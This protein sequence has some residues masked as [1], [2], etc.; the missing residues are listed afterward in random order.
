MRCRQTMKLPSR[1]S[2]A[3]QYIHGI[4]GGRVSGRALDRL[5]KSEA[6]GQERGHPLTPPFSPLYQLRRAPRRAPRRALR[7]DTEVG[8]GKGYKGSAESSS[9]TTRAPSPTLGASPLLFGSTSLA[10]LPACLLLA[11]CPSHDVIATEMCL[12]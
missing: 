4:L 2:Q 7:D 10:C 9:A 6:F 12:P 1:V 11:A 5:S 3:T 8:M